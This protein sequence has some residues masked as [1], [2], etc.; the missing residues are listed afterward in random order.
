M[1]PSFPAF[2][3]I[4]QPVWI[5]VRWASKNAGRIFKSSRYGGSKMEMELWYFTKI[6]KRWYSYTSV[7]GWQRQ[8]KCCDALRT[9]SLGCSKVFDEQVCTSVGFH[10]RWW[11]SASSNLECCNLGVVESAIW[12]WDQSTFVLDN[13]WARFQQGRCDYNG[14]CQCRCWSYWMSSIFTSAKIS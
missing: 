8:P 4:S 14:R 5:P 10:L 6:R 12:R 2:V 3:Q 9:S 11:K 13:R 1:R 7:N